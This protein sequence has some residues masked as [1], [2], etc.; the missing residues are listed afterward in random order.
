MLKHVI[1]LLVVSILVILFMSYAQT[2]LVWIV[3]A[4]DWVADMR[5]QVFS[6]GQAGD[7]TRQL[8]AL[9]SIPLAIGFIPVIVFW[10]AKRQWFPY[11]MQVVWVVWLVQTAAL[12]IQYKTAI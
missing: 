6:G 9:L 3:A 10:L 1:V 5:T 12:V 4:H 2:G 8:L 11:F 7:I